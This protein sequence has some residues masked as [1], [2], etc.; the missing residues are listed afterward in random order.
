MNSR[1]SGQ[2][3]VCA[4]LILSLAAGVLGQRGTQS[5][6]S[7]LQ[8]L[9]VMR[10]KL[11]SMRRSLNSAISS[12]AAPSEKDQKNPDDPRE[13]LRGLDKEVG[14][15]LSEVSDVRA[16]QERSERYDATIVDRLE[17]S[18]ADIS[19]R[20]EAGLQATA[21]ARSASVTT[22]SSRGKKKKKGRFFGLLGG[23][24]DEKYEELTGT[25]APGRDRVLFEEAAK[26]VRKGSHET[27]RLLF[28]TIIN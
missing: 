12:M 27:G 5:E 4:A 14:S 25:V 15:I 26:Q 16:K 13:R 10:S 8:R 22:S 24:G 28:S 21:S 11:E 9:D 6:L 7:A 2:L 23:G 1:F 19:T 17:T 20:V 18:V 3:I